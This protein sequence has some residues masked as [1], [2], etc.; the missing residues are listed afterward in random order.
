L[1]TLIFCIR[2]FLPIL[3]SIPTNFGAVSQCG[4]PKAPHPCGLLSSFH[5]GKNYPSKV[6]VHEVLVFILVC[7]SGISKDSHAKRDPAKILLE[8]HTH[9]VAFNPSLANIR[10]ERK[11]KLSEFYQGEIDCQVGFCLALGG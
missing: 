8:L 6:T 3:S 4:A 5:Q 10:R 7:S 1:L 11:A 9:R 2:P